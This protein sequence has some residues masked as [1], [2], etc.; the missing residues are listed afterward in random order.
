M[1]FGKLRSYRIDYSRSLRVGVRTKEEITL[2]DIE[3]QAKEHYFTWEPVT[4]GHLAFKWVGEKQPYP[5]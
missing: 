1:I 5:R 2:A 3:R 4:K